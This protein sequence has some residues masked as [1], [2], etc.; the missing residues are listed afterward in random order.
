LPGAGSEEAVGYAL[1]S[2]GT[3]SG[4]SEANISRPPSAAIAGVVLDR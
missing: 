3:T 2:P 1:W 4:E